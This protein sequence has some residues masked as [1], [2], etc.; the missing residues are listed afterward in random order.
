MQNSIT[1]SPANEEIGLKL[2]ALEHI[3]W[4]MSMGFTHQ[5]FLSLVS[6]HYPKYSKTPCKGRLSNW[7]YTKIVDS[8]INENVES[9][10][11]LL[12]NE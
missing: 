11:R 3:N 12:K 1:I 10:I 6:F 2:K 7:W 8:E 5:A 9:V 4:F